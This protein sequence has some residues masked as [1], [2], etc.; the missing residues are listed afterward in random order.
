MPDRA[1]L[2]TQPHGGALLQGG[3]TGNR[4]RWRGR[5]L[6]ALNKAALA[7]RAGQDDNP[8]ITLAAD[9][10]VEVAAG[11]AILERIGTK[12][13]GSPI[14]AETKNSDRLNAI[15]LMLAYILGKPDQKL[16]LEDETRRPTGEETMARLAAVMPQLLDRL[17][18]D[19]DQLRE[20][21]NDRRR[22]ELQVSGRVVEEPKKPKGG[23]KATP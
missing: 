15:E 5:F 1:A 12:R 22:R 17:P 10:L 2:V 7:K 3:N 18:V 21:L 14:F 13:D 20:V 6:E 19:V 16:A 8:A 11:D 9:I 4:G 23:K